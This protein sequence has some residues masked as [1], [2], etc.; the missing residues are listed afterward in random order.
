LVRV[1]SLELGQHDGALGVAGDRGGETLEATGG[2]DRILA[3]EV[4]DDALL[5]AAVLADGLDQIEVGVAVDVLFADEHAELAAE[6]AE[7][8]QLT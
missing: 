4:L 1:A 2:E 7:F 6:L 3:A 8:G 5:G